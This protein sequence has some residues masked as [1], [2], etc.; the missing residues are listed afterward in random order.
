MKVHINTQVKNEGLLLEQVLPFWKDYPV[1]KFVFY[2]DRSSDKTSEVIGDFLGDKAKIFETEG[3]AP[4]GPHLS[5]NYNEAHM[6]STMM[7]YSRHTEAG[8]IIALDA[9]ELISKSILDSFDAVVQASMKNALYFYWHNVVGGSLKKI[10]QDPLY[11]QNYRVFIVPLKFSNGYDLKTSQQNMNAI[12]ETPRTPE[13]YLPPQVVHRD[14]GFIHLQAINTRFYALK[15]LFYKI[16]ENKE[17]GR[18]AKELF[19]YDEVVN[20]FDFCEIDTPKAVIGD[21]DFDASVFDKIL[22]E[23]KYAEYVKEYGTEDLVTF[24]REYL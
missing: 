4:D 19:F 5:K 15:Q 13:I 6:R 21:W 8:A 18:P 23:R 24:G 17:Y 3:A 2:N 9:D 1:D 11:L 20:K 7:N 14:Y 16:F 10:R 12:H 22:E